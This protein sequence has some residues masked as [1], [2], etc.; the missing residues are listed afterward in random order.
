MFK[1]DYNSTT[2]SVKSSALIA[3]EMNHIVP[4]SLHIFLGIGQNTFLTLLTL[5]LSGDDTKKAIF[6][7][8]KKYRI[9]LK[10]RYVTFTSL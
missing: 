5:K 4:L 1:G 8:L 6:S 2:S 10:T 7:V 9:I 3:V